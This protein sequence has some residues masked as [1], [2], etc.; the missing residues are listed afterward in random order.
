M[1][2]W[3]IEWYVG[4]HI[5]VVCTC[6]LPFAVYIV[7]EC[8]CEALACGVLCMC[9]PFLVCMYM[10]FSGCFAYEHPDTAVTPGLAD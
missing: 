8:K 1:C 6:P 9:I 7:W 4:A 3:F 2:V 10:Y 5:S